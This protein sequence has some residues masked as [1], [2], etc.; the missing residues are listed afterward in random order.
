MAESNG[1][2]RIK[3][4]TPLDQFGTTEAEIRKSDQVRPRGRVYRNAASINGRGMN[5]KGMKSGKPFLCHPPPA[6]ATLPNYNREMRGIREKGKA[7]ETIPI[8]VQIGRAS[9][10]ER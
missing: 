2:R 9:C 10:R 1:S 6:P 5:G 7:E 4:I 8:P 3:G